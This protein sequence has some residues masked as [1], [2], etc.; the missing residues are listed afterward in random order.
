M[1]PFWADHYE[2]TKN[3]RVRTTSAKHMALYTYRE[4]DGLRTSCCRL[5]GEGVL[6][7]P[8][9]QAFRL[10]QGTARGEWSRIEHADDRLRELPGDCAN[11]TKLIDAGEF[12]PQPRRESV[13]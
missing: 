11:L 12:G 5:W 13:S 4:R 7:W 6:R 2:V 3:L 1:L 8:F 9:R 10:A